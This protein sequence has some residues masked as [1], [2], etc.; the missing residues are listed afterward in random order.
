[1]SRTDNEANPAI[2]P[3]AILVAPVTAGDEVVIGTAVDLLRR[4]LPR[5]AEEH[6]DLPGGPVDVIHVGGGTLSAPA[7]Y[8]LSVLVGTTGSCETIAELWSQRD[9][10][11]VEA[12]SVNT[13][14]CDPVV[15]CVS[16]PTAR[17]VL[18]AAHRLLRKLALGGGPS[19]IES[20]DLQVI[21]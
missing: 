3:I 9:R 16:S 20:F 18:Y 6:T 19:D 5:Q 13:L 7:G 1:M 21:H 11:E 12:H 14:T 2:A 4:K 8:K 15:L 17:G 10:T